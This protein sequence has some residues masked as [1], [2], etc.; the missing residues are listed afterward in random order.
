MS[1]FTLEVIQRF[2]PRP[3]SANH[4]AVWDQYVAALVEDGDAL[5]TEF[6]L[7]EALE[8]QHFMAQIAH[9]CGGFTILW[10]SGAYSAA[11]IMR[12]FG[13]G[14]HTAGVSQ[15]EAN[16][17]ASLPVEERTKVLFER[18][19]GLGNPKKA[20]ELGNREPG[21]GWRYRG[22]GPMQTT[23]RTD[24]ERLL[25]GDHSASSALRAAFREWDK[26][27][28]N[29]LARADDIKMI[30]KRIN[31]GY[32]GLD[33][34]RAWLAKAKRVWPRLSGDGPGR[35]P[36][37]SMI[38]STTARAAET[39]GVGGGINTSVEVSTAMAKVADKGTFSLE[40]FLLALASSPT[41]WIGVL[42]IA[43]A[44]YIWLERRR[45]LIVH[46]V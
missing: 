18:V 30:T 4:A 7:D 37:Q 35:A 36:P 2:A 45:K 23:G 24:H 25:G 46:G 6:G 44:A 33:S 39:V 34:R 40:A 29:D 22:F 19:Y 20:R 3:T 1:I 14:K 11:T 27:N 12:I 5:C 21:D 13:V 41:F 43:A 8:V 32:N 9:E 31:G 10:E 38:G 26:K 42:S 28:C 15:S 16:R 17:I